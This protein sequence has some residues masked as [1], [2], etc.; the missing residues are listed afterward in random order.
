[1]A[2]CCGLG[3]GEGS[4][5]GGSAG[6]GLAF[7]KAVELG[8]LVGPVLINQGY[9]ILNLNLGLALVLLPGAVILGQVFTRCLGVRSFR[10]LL[11]PGDF[12]DS[13]LCSRLRYLIRILSSL[14]LGPGLAV[15]LVL[16]V[17]LSS[18]LE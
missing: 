14:H 17:G 1:M 13:V 2:A 11:S 15:A 9:L 10:F 4:G 12:V 16:L 5:G 18:L 8:R 6:S 3:G 7:L